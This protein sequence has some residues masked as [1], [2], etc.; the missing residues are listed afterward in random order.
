MRPNAIEFWT[1]TAKRWLV[2]QP[3]QNNAADDPR[4]HSERLVGSAY[5][6]VEHLKTSLLEEEDDAFDGDDVA[7]LLKHKNKG[8]ASWQ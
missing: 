7:L 3:V 2:N 4:S 1:R 8:T 6:R 5:A